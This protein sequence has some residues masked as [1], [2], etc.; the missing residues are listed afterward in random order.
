MSPGVHRIALGLDLRLGLLKLLVECAQSHELILLWV[1]PLIPCY[2]NS[3]N[4]LLCG[5]FS[6][7]LASLLAKVRIKESP[8][9]KELKAVVNT[10]EIYF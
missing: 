8:V 4:S 3:F 1:D 6:K 2:F 10:G 5:T 9:Y 7:A